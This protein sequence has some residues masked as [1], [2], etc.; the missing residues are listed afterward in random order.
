M[1]LTH[2]IDRWGTIGLFLTAIVSPCC[3][4]IFAFGASL[5]GLGS[6]ELFGG[7]TMGI[8]QAMIVL[9]IAGL[10]ISCFQHRYM[11]PLLIAI[12]SATLIFYSYHF[13]NSDYYQ[14]LIYI[15]MVGMLAATWV[16]HMKN[17]NHNR[18]GIQENPAIAVNLTSTITCPDCGFQKTETMATDSCQYFYKCTN[19]EAILKPQKGDCCVFCSY[20]T[21]KCPPIQQNKS[22][23]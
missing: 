22:C 8:F 21:V 17:K 9:S 4:P 13:D 3:F 20:G 23:C 15:G 16:N 19:C 18:S 2:N 6:A 10:F 5:F 7:W 1:K 11:Y 12:P 14:Y